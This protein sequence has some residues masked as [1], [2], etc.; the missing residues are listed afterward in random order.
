MIIIHVKHYL[1]PQGLRFF[2]E[3]FDLCHTFLSKQAGFI[4]LQRAY[5]NTEP[6]T[7]HI[8]LHFETREQLIPWGNSNEHASLISKL[9]PYRIKEWEATWY[10]TEQACV[11][12]FI[13]P[14]GK[15]SVLT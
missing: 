2:D 11:E 15:H 5:D 10:D 13:I 4:F 12:K 14:L 6:S 3:W 1:N 9:D 7:V 8:W